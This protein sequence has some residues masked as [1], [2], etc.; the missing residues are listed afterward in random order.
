[1]HYRKYK[2]LNTSLKVGLACINRLKFVMFNR[3][4]TRSLRL[5]GYDVRIYNRA[6]NQFKLI[7]QNRN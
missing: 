7:L 3:M 6:D 4:H 1:M 5:K 2:Q